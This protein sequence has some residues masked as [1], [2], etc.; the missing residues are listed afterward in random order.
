[1][2]SPEEFLRQAQEATGLS[3]FGEKSF[4]EGLWRLVEGLNTEARLTPQGDSF[5]A[6]RIL[7]HLKQRLQ[8][9]DL[10]GRHP[11]IEAQ[12]IS[13]PLIGVSLPRTGSTALSCL[14][15]RD[16][17]F[18]SLSAQASQSPGELVSHPDTIDSAVLAPSSRDRLSRFVP[19]GPEEPAECQELMALSFRS[20]L[21]L[22]FA[23]IPSYAEWLLQ[24]DMR[25]TYAYEARVL[26]ALQWHSPNRGWRL[27]APTHLLYLDAMSEVFPDA[28][29][30]VTHRNPVAVMRSVVHLY[31]TYIGQFSDSV[32]LDYVADL[33]LRQWSEGA[34]RMQDFRLHSDPMRF[35]DVAWADIHQRPIDA[36]SRIYDWLGLDL[37]EDFSLGMQAWLDYQQLHRQSIDYPSHETL[38]LDIGQIEFVFQGY[39]HLFSPYL[40]ERVVV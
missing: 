27:K 24:A 36:V 8:I 3:D 7:H 22:A 14:L 10:Y 25:S 26:K 19:A 33:N 38:H 40:V 37:T 6:S 31:A 39:R 17:R 12:V 11:E 32:D 21:F 4:E 1:V 30:L 29:W 16:S 18:Q 2:Q 28:R 34:Q 20:Q 15:A 23:Q 9:E 35:F 13:A 5:L